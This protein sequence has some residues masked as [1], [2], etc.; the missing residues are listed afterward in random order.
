[1][2]YEKDMMEKMGKGEPTNDHL[3]IPLLKYMWDASPL[4]FLSSKE[5]YHDFFKKI[6]VLASF[7]E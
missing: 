5:S 6:S 7:S 1:M 3:D 2:S 4:S